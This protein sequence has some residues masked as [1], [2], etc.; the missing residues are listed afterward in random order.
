[1]S[2]S[3]RRGFTL[4]EL[5]VVIAIIA[6]LAAILFPVFAQA[7]AAAKKTAALSNLK[8]LGT[9]TFLYMGDYDDWVSRKWWDMHVDMLPYTKNVDIFLD[10]A[11]SAPKPYLREFTNFRHSDMPADT[12]PTIPSGTF[13]TN[14]PVGVT[15]SA[16]NVP[17]IYGH[18]SRNDELIHNY[19][20]DGQSGGPINTSSNASTWRSVSDKILF[21]F[22]KDGATDNDTNDFDEDNACYFEPGGTNWNAIYNIMATRHTDGAP[23]GMLDGSAKYRKASWLRSMQGKLALNPACSQLPDNTN[24]SAALCTYQENQ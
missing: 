19:G 1:M 21:T 8:Q 9:A 4:I 10:P 18:F 6:I 5:L 23:M 12:T 14:V 3:T 13:Y 16:G 11:S 20:F 24:W 2:N 7:K 17:T 15:A 22:A